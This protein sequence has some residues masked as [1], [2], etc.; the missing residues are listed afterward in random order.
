MK[1][2]LFLLLLMPSIVF[3]QKVMKHT[4][5]AKESYSSIGRLYNINGRELAEYNNLDYNT[6]L[7]IG[8]V[9]NIPVKG[10]TSIPANNPN[11]PIV[12]TNQPIYH[13]LKQGESLYQLSRM[14]APTTVDNLRTWNNLSSD[15]L[16]LGSKLIVGYNKG[17]ATQ[18]EVLPEDN[19]APPQK[20][21]SEETSSKKEDRELKAEA[22]RLANE[23][24]KLEE[25]AAKVRK[26]QA[27][28]EERRLE[29]EKR[30]MQKNA[31]DA[32][33][34]R[35][36]NSSE[37][38]GFFKKNFTGTEGNLNSGRVGVFKSTSGWEDEK[39]YA[40][41]DDARPGTILKITNKETGKVVYVKV[42]DIIPKL[43]E[44]KSLF[45]RL[46]NAAASALGAEASEFNC[47][48]EF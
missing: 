10:N 34:K 48:V 40:L 12:P 7:S 26:Q 25:E 23:Q 21:K 1:K 6:G 15:N 13:I 35:Q 3:A 22:K 17:Q 44:N 5:A 28:L 27:E 46:S 14:Y 31:K 39:Y 45:L 33:Q 32:S 18:K 47:D 8:Q 20:V 30:T 42:L 2:F 36:I 19:S 16:I 29:E 41:Y 11:A 37:G 9:I 24:K 4:V 38:I 43:N